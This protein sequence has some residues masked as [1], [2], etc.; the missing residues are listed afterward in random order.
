MKK[1]VVLLFFFVFFFSKDCHTQD[2][3]TDSLLAVL[4]TQKADTARV[5]TL[6]ALSR[7]YVRSYQLS[8]ARKF[9]TEAQRLAEKLNFKKGM[10]EAKNNLGGIYNAEANG[11]MGKGNYIEGLKNYLTA[12]GIYERNDYNYGVAFVSG[13]IGRFYWVQKDYKEA[14]KFYSRAL[15]IFESIRDKKGIAW[16]QNNIGLLY[17]NQKQYGEAIRYYEQAIRTNEEADYRS[18]NINL[19]FNIGFLY[20]DQ[21]KYAEAINNHLIALKISQETAS[22]SGIAAAQTNI[23]DIQLKQEKFGEALKNYQDAFKL[24]QEMEDPD[25]ISLAYLNLGII[26]FHLKDIPNARKFLEEALAVA[27]KEQI[28]TTIRETYAMMLRVDSLA[29]NLPSALENYR[30]YI[31]YRDSLEGN[32]LKN[33]LRE[34]Q[35]QYS[36]TRKEDS[37]KLLQAVTDAKLE[38]QVLLGHQQEQDLLLKENELDL[39]NKEKSIRSLER[40]KDSTEKANQMAEVE[41][42]QNQLSLL[43]KEKDI[44]NLELKKQRQIKK[45]LFAGVGLLLVLAFFIYRNYRNRQQLKLMVLRNKIASDLHDDIGSTL[46][47]ISIFSQMAQQQSKDVVPLLESIGDHS[48]KMLDAMADIVWTI[49][50]ENDQFEDIILRMKSFAF[51][52]LGAKNIDFEFRADETV[53][54]MKL[55]MEVKKNLYLIFKEATNNLVKYSNAEKALFEIKSEKNNLSLLI[56]DYGKGFDTGKFTSGN[57]LR[58]MKKRAGDMNAQ[59]EVDSRPGNGTTVALK[60]TV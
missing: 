5:N 23:G 60:M 27:K 52:L 45:F 12:L 41:R 3:Y 29:G 55:P 14:M 32:D 19:Y 35:M 43:E 8:S 20:D 56:R 50:P 1:W 54:K 38:R 48:R 42:K 24:Y 28:N 26:Y 15:G 40:Q 13:N 25:G 21:G 6:N 44:Q 10:K 58:N 18:A 22:K 46:S 47:S 17:E 30:N 36:F 16:I 4:A 59:F 34:T 57:G 39:L 37:L 2:K 9:M 11:H 53:S 7:Q 51:E 49:K 31:L 33:K